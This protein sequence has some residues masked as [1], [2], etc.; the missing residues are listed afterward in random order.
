MLKIGRKAPAF[1]LLDQNGVAQSLKK[2]Q[3]TWVLIYFYPKDDTPGCT[4]E[5]CM[6]ADV[7]K[8]F[9]RLKVT[10]LGVSKDT[11]KSHLKFATKYNLPF[12]LLSDPTMEMMTKYGAFKE[13]K[14]FGKVARGTHR[15]S[16]L[17]HPLGT[18]AKVYPEVDPATHA[19]ELL[20]DIK[21]LQKEEKK[22]LKAEAG[23]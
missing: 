17:V 10:V 14:M 20:A 9:K 8:D 2:M 15:I 13:K 23:E 11:P 22:K 7:Y 4:K 18:I 5:A 3:G 16:Y 1:T 21:L 6:I 19:L 12:M